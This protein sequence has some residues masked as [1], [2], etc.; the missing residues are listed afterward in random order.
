VRDAC[1]RPRAVSSS[2]RSFPASRVGR[3]DRGEFACCWLSGF[4]L[5]R[6]LRLLPRFAGVPVC[7]LP[8]VVVPAGAASRHG[9]SLRFAPRAAAGGLPLA[10]FG[11]SQ[12]AVDSP[13]DHEHTS[14]QLTV[15]ILLRG[16]VDE[17][18]SLAALG[19]PCGP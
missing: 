8:E 4:A 10:P 17:R 5:R 1:C 15:S 13:H 7:W 14:M 2:L 12:H 3:G 6:R 19:R 9:R 16:G 11:R 18:A